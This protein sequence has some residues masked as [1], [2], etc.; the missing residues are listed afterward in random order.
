MLVL[1]LKADR[2]IGLSC[3]MNPPQLAS[4]RTSMHNG[5]TNSFS[6]SLSPFSV[7]L[8]AGCGGL[9]EGLEAAGIT[10]ILA[11][12]LHP[13]AALSFAFNHPDC[14]VS[15][16]DIR[17]YDVDL[18]SERV[19]QY[20]SGSELFLL[21][22]GPPC[23]GFSSAGKKQVDD[24]RNSL[25]SNFL[26][27]A[28]KLKPLNIVIENVPGFANRY[29]GKFLRYALEALNSLGYVCDYGILDFSEFGVPQRRSRF[30]LLAIRAELG[31]QP[32]LPKGKFVYT[33]S[34]EPLLQHC[35]KVTVE[36]AIS[37]LAAIFPGTEQ[38][39]Y[40]Y[41]PLSV[42]QR[43]R[44]EGVNSLYNHLSGTH[45]RQALEVFKMIPEGGN[46]RNVPD[47]IRSKKRT[48]VRAHRREV[49]N[50][51]VTLPDDLLH[52]S[53]NRILTVRETARIQSYDDSY[54]FLGKRTSCN[55]A[56][57]TEL[58]QYSQVGNS[59]PPVFAKALGEHLLALFGLESCDR[60]NF[61]Q[62]ERNR[63]YLV[64]NSAGGGYGLR[65]GVRLSLSDASFNP[66]RIPVINASPDHSE[67]ASISISRS[68]MTRQWIP[69]A[70]SA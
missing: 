27:I 19:S 36:E 66:V 41:K 57:R 15:Y 37:D 46:I 47:H 11:Q 12:E 13:Q 52:Y 45:R 58:P 51:I 53:E 20:D 49:S 56:R 54:V 35:Q 7:D 3:T 39:S 64:G 21:C 55:T 9:S 30:V 6:T 22:G 38:K 31:I 44:R 68:N 25:V 33:A 26:E 14:E 23:Q 62:R 34:E 43:F 59:V 16:G 40:C 50:T 2:R 17:S 48:L 24:P 70:S 1:G 4:Q 18:L 63:G 60:R 42:Y 67:A 61:A 32:S 10:C 8:F 69:Y 5:D 29:N 28:K 65:E